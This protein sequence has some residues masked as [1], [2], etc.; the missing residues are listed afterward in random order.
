[1][2]YT[3]HGALT[4]WALAH[5]RWRKRAVRW[6]W[7]DR[8]L[9]DAACIQV[10]SRQELAEARTLGMSNP[11]AVIPNGVELAPFDALQRT[12]VDSS[13]SHGRRPVA[14]FLGRLHAKKGLG[15]LLEA[16]SRAH[17]NHADWRLVIAGPDD[18]YEEQARRLTGVLGLHSSVTFAG[19]LRGQDKVAALRAAD[20]FVLPSF[21]EGFS[22]AVLEAMAARLPVVL[23]PGCNFP[24]AA[25]AGAALEVQP[26]VAD[27]ERG[28]RALMSM[29]EQSRRAMGYRGRRLVETRYTWDAVARETI[30]IYRWLAG[31]AAVPSFVE[32]H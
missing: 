22:M 15:H 17:A 13:R 20:A 29:P 21:S 26:T 14:L 31:V 19:P 24:E 12:P 32:F 6:W 16:W 28:L 7:Q 25:A 23:T 2:L 3:A 5:S 10:N 1:V 9:R 8:D 11:V 18:G 4:P 30:E 27:T